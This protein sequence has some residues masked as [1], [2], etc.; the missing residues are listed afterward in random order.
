[1]RTHRVQQIHD[2]DDDDDDAGRHIDSDGDGLPGSSKG[3]NSMEDKALRVENPSCEAR[4]NRWMK[5]GEMEN[6]DQGKTKDFRNTYI[7]LRAT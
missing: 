1:M 3:R 2:G 5:E 6:Q 4:Q 7:S